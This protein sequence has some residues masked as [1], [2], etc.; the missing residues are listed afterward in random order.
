M[1]VGTR[2]GIVGALISATAAITVGGIIVRQTTIDLQQNAR[3][4]L[5]SRL[6]AVAPVVASAPT[7]AQLVSNL[8]ANSTTD[9]VRV[10]RDGVESRSGTMPV[11]AP[12][13]APGKVV[14]V[15]SGR[16]SWYA[17]SALVNI[18]SSIATSPVE[19]DMFY[20]LKDLNHR[21]LLIRRRVRFLLAVSVASSTVLSWLAGTYVTR[22]LRNLRRAVAGRRSIDGQRVPE[23][24]NVEEVD[25]LGRTINSL[26]DQLQVEHGQTVKALESAREFA[27]NAVHELRTPLTSIH[28]DLDVLKAHPDLD[29]AERVQ[30]IDN[31]ECQHQRLNATLSALHDL[32]RGEFQT[33]SEMSR[34]DLADVVEYAVDGAISIYSDATFEFTIPDHVF[35]MGW[36]EGLRLALDNLLANAVRH[37][38][39]R[40]TVALSAANGFAELIVADAGPGVPD[41]EKISIFERFSRGSSPAPGTGLGLA[42]VHQ[43]AQLHGG[44]IHVEDVEPHG[45]RLVW[46]LPLSDD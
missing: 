41:Q 19:V 35:V 33:R 46:R 44:D 45:V 15:R 25:E 4:D 42:L 6:T 13:L 27:Y 34:I 26:V 18:D 7:T 43:Q 28:T 8:A 21:L 24:Q 32:S 30:L 17:T 2:F 39:G 23:N 9:G 11:Q 1:N 31:I 5:S 10:V 20:P 22:P 38:G 40:V 3:H 16:Q 14:T 29:V 36:A 12:T 37:G